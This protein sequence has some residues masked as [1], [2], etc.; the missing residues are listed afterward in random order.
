MADFDDQLTALFQ[1]ET[2]P[3]LGE[4]MADRALIRIDQEDSRRQVILSIGV[5]S[6]LAL[7][8]AVAGVAGLL[9]A[10]RAISFTTPH[11][12]AIPYLWPLAGAAVAAAAITTL[13][14]SAR[15]A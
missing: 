14:R 10:L 1:A 9:P 4:R 13:V 8:G 11:I 6:G 15:T 2:N 3:A 7:A 5:V 12:T